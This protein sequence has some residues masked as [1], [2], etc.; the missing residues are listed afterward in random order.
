MSYL[1]KPYWCLI[2]YMVKFQTPG[3]Q[4]PLSSSLSATNLILP[5]FPIYNLIFSAIT[6][7]AALECVLSF[8]AFVPES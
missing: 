1:N 8:H 7:F 4:S 6:L 3:I 5:L 2:S